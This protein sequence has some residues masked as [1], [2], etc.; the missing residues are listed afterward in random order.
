MD[1]AV[2]AAIITG[3]L[4]LVLAV[5]NLLLTRR[6]HNRVVALEE[7]RSGLAREETA[8][9]AKLD[10]E[11]AARRGLY[12]SFEIKLFLLLELSDYALDGYGIL[13]TRMCGR[14]WLRAKRTLPLTSELPFPR[15]ETGWCRRSMDCTRR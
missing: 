10:Y 15:P 8:E 6:Q 9:K 14:N 5:A 2:I 12:D 1:P 13:R 11:Y 3:V 4:S 7:L